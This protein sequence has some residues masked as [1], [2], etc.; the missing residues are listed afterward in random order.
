MQVLW[1]VVGAF[2]F[3][4]MGVCIKYAASYFN[5]AEIVFYR[6]LIGMLVLWML[7][8]SQG[9]S[10]KTKHPW[11]HA[12]RSLVGVTAMGCWF[13]AITQMP[14]ASA[15]TL[16]YMSSIWIAAFLLAAALWS[17]H[18]KSGRPRQVLN[19]PLLLTIIMG[20]VGVLLMLQPS[21]AQEQTQAALI[22]LASG[23][24]SALAYM[25]VVSLS[26]IGEPES[27]TVF[28][29]GLGCTL[30]GLLACFVT[31]FSQWPGWQAAAWL[32]P[33]GLLAA[34]GQ[35]CMTKAYANAKTA[36][37]TLVVANLQYSGIVF[38]GMYSL[39]LFNDTLGWEGWLGMTLIV[40]SG[41]AATIFRARGISAPAP[42]KS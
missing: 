35:L 38:A 20:F 21:F 32:I 14:L 19:I 13:Y 23:L 1:M 25:Q 33:I 10:L 26:R 2:L 22:G 34:G 7:T 3:A 36:R 8:A 5:T 24:L 17:L 15:M 18:P 41:I 30:A 6:G 40:V 37:G 39:F 4:T 27:R 31:G 42:T 9:I 29:F 12:W 11:M 16:N 28:F